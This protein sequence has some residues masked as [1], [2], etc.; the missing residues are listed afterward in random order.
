MQFFKVRMKEIKAYF[1]LAWHCT[2]PNAAEPVEYNF[3]RYN[4]S[5]AKFLVYNERFT[6]RCDTYKISIFSI[7]F[8][9][10]WFR[11]CNSSSRIL[12]LAQLELNM[13]LNLTQKYFVCCAIDI[14]RAFGIC[15]KITSCQIQEIEC[16]RNLSARCIQ[17]Y[18]LRQSPFCSLFVENNQ[19]RRTKKT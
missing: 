12:T 1:S 16:A 6:L 9:R 14:S 19:Y 3:Y 10:S 17:F 15:D 8:A 18:K 4:I 13:L 11:Q 2:N 5:L 7:S